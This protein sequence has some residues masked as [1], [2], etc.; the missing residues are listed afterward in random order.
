MKYGKSS[1]TLI[2]LLVVI[3]IIAILAAILLPAL[4]SARERG[5]GASCQSNLKQIGVATTQYCDDNDMYTPNCLKTPEQ[6]RPLAQIAP[7]M[8]LARSADGLSLL[9]VEQ[10]YVCPSDTKPPTAWYHAS[11]AMNWMLVSEDAI[12]TIGATK[13]NKIP[14]PSIVIGWGDKG[15]KNLSSITA[16]T[17]YDAPANRPYYFRH[18]NAS[19][20]VAIGGNVRVIRTL[21]EWNAPRKKSQGRSTVALPWDPLDKEWQAM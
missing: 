17:V 11:Y 9:K 13:I 4:Q 10:I 18:K 16:Y 19:Q 5:R 7:Y 14:R 20:V 3:A 8:G 1:F 21:E 12:K 15:P 6:C 2:E